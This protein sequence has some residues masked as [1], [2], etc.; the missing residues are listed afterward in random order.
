MAVLIAIGLASLAFAALF[1]G[2]H[3]TR[4]SSIS[5]SEWA[6]ADGGTAGAG[7]I[8]AHIAPFYR[9]STAA[10]MDVVTLVNI[11][12][13]NLAATTPGPTSG[14]ELAVET[15]SSPSSVALLGGNTIAYNICGIGTSNCA[16]AGTPSSPR[17]LLLRRE[18]LELALYTLRYIGGTQNVVVLLPPARTQVASTL[19]PTR[20]TSAS[21]TRSIGLAVL[22]DRQ[23]L[24]PL[25]ARPLGSTLAP[26]P[27][28]VSQLPLWQSS[29]DAGIVDQITA[30]GLFSQRIEQLQDG[31][32]LLL[33]TELPPQ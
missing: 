14:L 17:L 23:E 27:P 33:L 19:G 24:A 10:Q 15:G 32:H 7:E 8:A 18:A 29:E 9:A 5:W 21:P 26:F 30:R 22:F 28:F 12:N 13:P 4:R 6:P 2:H 11:A 3:S 31:S 20:P 25:L 16:L 1:A